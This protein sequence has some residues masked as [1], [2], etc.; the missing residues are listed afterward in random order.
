MTGDTDFLELYQALGLEPGCDL[1]TFQLAYRRRISLLH[2][3]RQDFDA[4]QNVTSVQLNELTTAY[5]AAMQFYRTHG[6]LPGEPASTRH[7]PPNHVR[8]RPSLSPMPSQQPRKRRRPG[9]WVLVLF[10]VAIIAVF[11]THPE[12]PSP[13]PMDPQTIPVPA[14][15][16][17]QQPSGSLLLEL[18]M[19][20]QEARR[21]QG[22]PDMIEGN[23]WDYG[24]SWILIEDGK[25][26]DWYSS[27][28]RPLNVSASTP[29][30]ERR[31]AR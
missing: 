2:P 12:S 8:I 17:H 27:P 11:W 9:L 14:D 26:A 19:P 15:L 16:T 28:L 22:E 3:D 23:R 13:P 30:E 18:G 31:V 7:C 29:R 1:A 10:V 20:Q 24:P 6:R 4:E 21:I 5:R 25:V